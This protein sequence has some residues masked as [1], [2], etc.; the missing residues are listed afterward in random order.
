MTAPFGLGRTVT[1]LSIAR[2]EGTMR[3]IVHIRRTTVVLATMVAVSL[4]S[5]ALPLV[6]MASLGDGGGH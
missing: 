3:R 4:L 1:A 6:A 5:A 2:K